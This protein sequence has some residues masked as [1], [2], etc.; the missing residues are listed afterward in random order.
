MLGIYRKILRMNLHQVPV[1]KIQNQD[2][3]LSSFLLRIH[4]NILRVNLHQVPVYILQTKIENEHYEV[5]FNHI[6]NP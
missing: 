2:Y 1:H 3:E 6:K 5:K 4:E